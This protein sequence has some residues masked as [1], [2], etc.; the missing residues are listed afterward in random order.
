[1][2]GSNGSDYYVSRKRVLLRDFDRMAGQV[3][4]VV[5]SPYSEML[6]WGLIR[7][8]TLAEGAGKCDF[9]FKKGGP[10]RVALP[11]SLRTIQEKAR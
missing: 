4:D 9:R 10:T 3:R 5:A 8:Q 6:D 7:T 1:M 2:T 11:A